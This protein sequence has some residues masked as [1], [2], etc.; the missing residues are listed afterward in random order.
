[1]PLA[2]RVHA[3]ACGL[4]NQLAYTLEIVCC[5]PKRAQQ[6]SLLGWLHTTT[7]TLMVVYFKMIFMY[8]AVTDY[9]E[10]PSHMVVTI[11]H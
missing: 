8:I 1:M 6:V 9:M 2:L 3:M 7:A 4:G 11:N 5:C 10:K